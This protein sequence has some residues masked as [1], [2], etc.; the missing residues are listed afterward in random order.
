MSDYDSGELEEG[1]S[2]EEELSYSEDTEHED[3][4]RRHRSRSRSRSRRRSH[5]PRRR[6][7]SHR[8][9]PRSSRSGSD[10]PEDA[11]AGQD[12]P[13]P[14]A[15][16]ATA[17]AAAAAAGSDAP[18]MMMCSEHSNNLVPLTC[19]TCK[20]IAHMLRKDVRDQL[21]VDDSVG[22]S[23]VPS[24]K[25]RL[26][27][28]RSDSLP[29]TL[30]FTEEELQLH[31][32]IHGQGTFRRGHFD[33]VTK[34]YLRLS[35]TQHQEVHQ[36]IETE[37]L[38]ARYANNPKYQHIFNYKRDVLTCSRELK[39]CT[40]PFVKAM[41]AAT[42]LA[43]EVRA[44]GENVG[45]TYPVKPLEVEMRGPT[46]VLDCLT[47]E[48]TSNFLPLPSM[49]DPLHGVQ[50]DDVAKSLIR[51]NHATNMTALVEYHA[52]ASSAFARLYSPVAKS[53]LEIDNNLTFTSELIGHV[54]GTITDL[55]KKKLLT[56]FKGD[57][58][59]IYFCGII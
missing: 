39:V 2:S 5:S 57:A 34:K 28:Q 51:T 16:T 49:V 3:G 43:R 11:R 36:Y 47:P 13:A 35:K 50:V 23:A 44:A 15:D 45:Y 12:A 25:E 22:P 9:S 40:R 6:R 33:E 8:R 20:H 56:V 29:A 52:R 42:D 10:R 54:D 4:P 53:S 1:R 41:S 32:E 30:I 31:K 48:D 46:P 55:A 27:R 18:K 7:R 14:A 19:S 26:R 58:R 59:G 21:V 37:R 24:T 38:F 17:T